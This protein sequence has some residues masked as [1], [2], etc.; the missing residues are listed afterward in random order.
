MVRYRPQITK[1][2]KVPLRVSLV[3]FIIGGLWIFTSDLV[4][5]AFSSS[6]EFVR[7]AQVLKGCVFIALTA[8]L[9]YYLISSGI[10]DLDNERE[11]FSLTLKGSPI[12]TFYQDLDLRYTWI[13]NCAPFFQPEEIIGKTDYE[14]FDLQYAEKMTTMKEQVLKTGEKITCE[15]QFRHKDEI[16]YFQENIYPVFDAEKKICGINCVAINLTDKKKAEQR[17]IESEDRY[18][19]LV[20]MSPDVIAIHCDGILVYVNE[21]GLR[22]FGAGRQ[23]EILG[24]PILNFIHPDYRQASVERHRRMMISGIAEPSVIEKL[25]TATGEIKVFEIV[26]VPTIFKGKIAIQVIARNI[27]ERIKAEEAHRLSEEK[28][29]ALFESSPVGIVITQQSKILQ[30]NPAYAR[31]F[32]YEVDE[33]LNS[34]VIENIAPGDRYLMAE[35]A[36]QESQG[37]YVSNSYDGHGIKKDGTE[38]PVHVELAF[39]EL[40]DGK[41]AI[42]LVSDTTEVTQREDKIKTSLKEKEILLK[43][44]HHRVK[45]NLQI[46]S[47]L[48]S[49]QSGYIKDPESLALFIDSQNRIKSMAI[50]HERLY[51]STDLSRIDFGDYITNLSGY[52]Q[53]IYEMNNG[54]IQL[55][56]DLDRIFI[57][58]ETAIPC[59]L[60]IN[61]LL[62]N[63]MKYAFAGCDTGCVYVSLKETG[64]NEYK[65]IVADDGKGLPAGLN[66]RKTESLGL[67]LVNSLVEQL[68]GKIELSNGRGTTFTITFPA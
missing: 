26:A 48:L 23:E 13:Y 37:G 2:Y 30:V 57:S 33:L 53:K 36:Q 40:S 28:F 50:I 46:I 38:F 63:S 68:N 31:I 9:I 41:A 16:I 15:V 12:I 7:E 66:F 18:R 3:Y 54:N 22:F 1:K 64:N 27:D 52:L 65:I 51:Q 32:G 10:D 44:I 61:E 39:V 42:A 56:L 59:G 11:F 60:I 6:S 25:L 55:T 8:L 43:E 19:R 34:S 45:N 17:I 14:L 58:I 20:E 47:S 21:A 62:S 49:L 4:L 29:R 24:T 35:R 5:Y 67:S